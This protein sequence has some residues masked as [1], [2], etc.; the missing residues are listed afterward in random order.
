MHIV[1]LTEDQSETAEITNLR[2]GYNRNW[3]FRQN[4]GM[5]AH[6]SFGKAG[7]GGGSGAFK[8]IIVS[9]QN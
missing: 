3:I 5:G 1:F 6:F 4:I 7:N 9:N 2:I 8:I